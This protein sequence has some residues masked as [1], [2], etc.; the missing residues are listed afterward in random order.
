VTLL[1]SIA[2]ADAIFV[3]SGSN[4]QGQ[5]E[6]EA[7][8]TLVNANT[9][10]ITLENIDPRPAETNADLLSGLFFNVTGSPTLLTTAAV[11]APGSS[12]VDSPF[13]PTG[14]NT[15]TGPGTDVA[16][17]WAYKEGA[18]SGFSGLNYGFA[19]AGLGGAF[20]SGDV[21]ESGARWGAQGGSAPN[22]LDF[23][24]LPTSN[25][26]PP[27]CGSGCDNQGPFVQY[28][29]VFTLTG[30]TGHSLNDIYGV[31]FQ[32]GTAPSLTEVCIGC[33][34][35]TG[36][37]GTTTT[38]SVETTTTTDTTTTDT[39][40]TGTTTTG[41]P[42]TTDT[43]TTDI[44]INSTVPEPATLALFATGLGLASS[45]LRRRRSK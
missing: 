37:T 24:L 22:G 45:R 12:I 30:F 26:A 43:T 8:F 32:Y 44:V 42:T 18:I 31:A 29:V 9:L 35:T 41:G 28:A 19:S 38:T 17:E 10:Q 1:P 27:S 14:S 16:V 2:R 36:T 25:T 6:A 23:S 33:T 7:I 13:T 15:G 3:G 4:A 11:V 5:L 34:T 39:T 20:G 21:I 40:T